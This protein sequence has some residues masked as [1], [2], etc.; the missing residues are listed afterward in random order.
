MSDFIDT[1]KFPKF[2]AQSGFIDWLNEISKSADIKD[3]NP[4]LKPKQTPD[5][6]V[7]DD[8]TPYTQFD[9]TQT[10]PDFSVLS[11]IGDPRFSLGHML[12]AAI[13]EFVPRIELYTEVL[14]AGGC[15]IIDEY[16]CNADGVPIKRTISKCP[17]SLKTLEPLQPQEVVDFVTNKYNEKINEDILAFTDNVKKEY[18]DNGYVVR[19]ITIK[20][21]D[22]N[23][24]AEAKKGKET[25]Y[26]KYYSTDKEEVSRVLNI[27]ITVIDPFQNIGNLQNPR[28]PVLTLDMITALSVPVEVYN[29]N[30]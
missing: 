21:M 12:S 18:I 9:Y 2:G 15:Q 30:I 23:F 26:L 25:K 28:E 8:G 29:K 1:S 22:Y 4:I 11:A 16:I 14:Q 6:Y 17:E 20:G 13:D 3:F 19:L 7:N 27:P 24:F 10:I 5:G